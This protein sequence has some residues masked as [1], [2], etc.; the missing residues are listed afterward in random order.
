L[1]EKLAVMLKQDKVMIMIPVSSSVE[2]AQMCPEHR[3]VGQQWVSG[4]G[5]KHIS[6]VCLKTIECCRNEPQYPE[7]LL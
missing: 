3:S 2:R 7:I 6:F 4:W 1:G 5:V